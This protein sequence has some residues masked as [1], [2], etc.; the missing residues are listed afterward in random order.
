MDYEFMP[1]NSTYSCVEGVI[2]V[3]FFRLNLDTYTKQF[4]FDT[5]KRNEFN[6]LQNYTYI[7]YFVCVFT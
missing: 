6:V 7:I 5:W 2:V 3:F 1:F 4:K